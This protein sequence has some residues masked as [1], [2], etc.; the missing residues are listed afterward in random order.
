MSQPSSQSQPPLAPP[1]LPPLL[2]RQ[3]CL[4]ATLA[5]LAALPPRG[6][7]VWA[8]TAAILLWLGMGARA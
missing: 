7:P 3:A 5:G 8:V 1:L 4:L 2:Y 6:E